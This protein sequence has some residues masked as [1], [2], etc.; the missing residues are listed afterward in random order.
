VIGSG[1]KIPCVETVVT[2][3]SGDERKDLEGPTDS[4]QDTCVASAHLQGADKA[5]RAARACET[6]PSFACAPL[7]A[8]VD[9]AAA[10]VARGLR[11]IR[12][13]LDGTVGCRANPSPRR[14]ATGPSIKGP[15]SK[16]RQRGLP[17][18]LS[19]VCSV[20][21]TAPRSSL[22][23]SSHQHQ[24]GVDVGRNRSASCKSAA[25][26]GRRRRRRA[27]RCSS[28]TGSDAPFRPMSRSGSPSEACGPRV[29]QDRRC[30]RPRSWR[31][32]C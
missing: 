2:P 29:Q 3:N 15:G 25:V 20:H 14:A 22:R 11:R 19:F 32:C 10:R 21:A 16:S 23:P 13:G 1:G 5:F 27:R 17:A 31:G 30:C 9:G 4:V 18:L 6:P 26:Q 8:G 28:G 12:F 7:E 24:K